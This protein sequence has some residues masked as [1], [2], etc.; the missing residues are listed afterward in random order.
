[1]SDPLNDAATSL[2]AR[3]ERC[4]RLSAYMPDEGTRA[5]LLQMASDYFER[6]V[7]LEEKQR[8]RDQ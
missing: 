8:K 4:M 5:A 7:H 3:A 2:R 6:A 1:M